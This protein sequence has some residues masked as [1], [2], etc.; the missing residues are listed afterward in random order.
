MK[1]QRFTNRIRRASAR[2]GYSVAR[3][4]FWLARGFIHYMPYAVKSPSKSTPPKGHKKIMVYADD[5][6]LLQGEAKRLKMPFDCFLRGLLP[7]A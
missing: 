2:W 7:L 6:A 3:L 5:W 4:N 1:Q